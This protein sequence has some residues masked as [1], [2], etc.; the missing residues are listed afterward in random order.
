MSLN[1]QE[2]SFDIGARRLNVT[3]LGFW[4]SQLLIAIVF[5]LCCSAGLLLTA[6]RTLNQAAFLDP[7][8]Y[9]GYIHD[10]GG[11]LLRFGRSYFSTRVAYI[12]PERILAHLTDF[13]TG[14]FTF[15][16]I[17][18]SSAAA[19]VFMIGT[20]FFGYGPA[21]FAVV[22]LIF[23]PWLPRS[24]LWTHYDGAAIVYVLVG[25]A[26]VLVPTKRR[27]LWHAAAGVAFALAVNCNLMLLA[28]CGLLGPAWT[29]FYWR[30]GIAWLTRA[31][32]A[33]AAGFFG[34][35]LA[36]ALALYLKFPG[37][38]FFFE[39]AAIREA[40]FVLGGAQ[41]IW[42]EPLSVIIWQNHDFK[43]LIPITL[44]SIGL[45]AVA[46]RVIA[47]GIKTG[48][49]NFE[50]FAFI[51]LLSICCLFLVF[52]F[53]FHAFW[54]GIPEYAIYLLP[55]CTLGIIVLGGE[56]ARRGGPVI[57]TGM[58]FGGAALILLVWLARPALPRLEIASNFV[59][60]VA[61]A[62]T[63][64]AAALMMF[65]RFTTASVVAL[66]GV[67]LLTQ[68]LYQSSFYRIRATP[69]E[70]NITEW[71]I[72]RGALFLHQF[73]STHVSANEPIGFWYANNKLSYLN[74]VQAFY[75]AHASRVF[76]EDGPGMP[77]VDEQFRERVSRLRY[78]FLLG[79]SDA[80]IDNGVAALEAAGL[81][82][83]EIE[84]TRTHYQGQLWGYV[85]ALVRMK[86]PTRTLGPLLV[87]VQLPNLSAD[88][89]ISLPLSSFQ[90][91]NGAQS[92][93]LPEGLRLTT[94]EEQWAYSSIGRIRPYVQ[95]V[96]APVVVH[97]RL[98]VETGKIG[99]AVT[100]VE[101]I[102]SVIREIGVAA[103]SN[104]QEVN[105]D[106]P[107]GSVADLLILRNQSPNG[108]SRVVVYAAELL[109]ARGS[110]P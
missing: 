70:D 24:L 75:L 79:A 103:G 67:A 26:C 29:V 54:L 2:E 3:A 8:I 38:G 49:C 47:T 89:E 51:Y 9:A 7:Y 83:A 72:Y 92:T 63:T 90:S 31:V 48:A 80:E 1:K 5:G 88:N 4:Q 33:L 40:I 13:E 11:L 28:V 110:A 23:T 52:H 77:F 61:V 19:A 84:I 98:K 22:W 12:Y 59:F 46:E 109:K 99:I 78:L 60:W 85:A 21:I 25:T 87:D 86:P 16:I 69:P 44:L 14:Y 97:L 94:G 43:L 27:L 73:V 104:V 105:L 10:Y 30:E 71:D 41:T 95:S 39:S 32:L 93:M 15:R 64:V 17:A 100:R 20:R 102:S 57:G 62:G 96:R 81:Q 45:M 55:G 34:A 56:V 65:R 74:S 68:C 36:I 76:P 53:E 35:Y 107:D 37:Y 42:Y 58:L 18:L 101:N 82:S 108:R 6:S 66:A 50:G 106:I 91:A